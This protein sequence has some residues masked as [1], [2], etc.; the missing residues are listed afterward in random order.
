MKACVFTLGCKQ[1]EVE[2]ASLM[3]GLEARGFEVTDELGKADLYLLNTCGVTAEAE[4]T[5]ENGAAS[6]SSSA[7]RHSAASAARKKRL[8]IRCSP[9][10]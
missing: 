7:A 6:A 1:N 10:F 2:S 8:F 9:P 3:R 4:R 5:S